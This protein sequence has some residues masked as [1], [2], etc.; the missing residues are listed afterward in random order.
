MRKSIKSSGTV[1]AALFALAACSEEPEPVQPIENDMM[2]DSAIPDDTTTAPGALGLTM[3][4]LADADILDASG[5]DIGEVERVETDA[6]G[7]VTMLIVEVDDTE[8]D[9]FVQLP[10]DNLT[11][12]MQGDDY[13]LQ[14]DL[15]RDALLNMEKAGMQ[16]AAAM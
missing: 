12:V 7:N 2:S 6:Q 10:L 1:V 8:P 15:D 11:A 9:V 3:Q 5:Q 16:P 13:G 14:G 4:Q